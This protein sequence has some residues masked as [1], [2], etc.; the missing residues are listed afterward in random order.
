MGFIISK[1]VTRPGG[2]EGD[3][4]PKFHLVLGSSTG[5][6][7]NYIV[8]TEKKSVVLHDT[9]VKSEGRSA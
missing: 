7:L 2:K 9:I 4:F 3:D 5:S 6:S 8:D 1:S